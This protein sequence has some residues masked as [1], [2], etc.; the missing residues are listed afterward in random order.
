MKLILGM[1]KI[2]DD[3]LQQGEIQLKCCEF[4]INFMMC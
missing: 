3:K 1:N 2:S 4:M